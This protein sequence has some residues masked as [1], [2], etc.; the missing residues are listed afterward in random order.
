MQAYYY[1]YIGQESLTWLTKKAVKLVQ[2]NDH[3]A[4]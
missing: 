1:M 4:A 2:E 3:A